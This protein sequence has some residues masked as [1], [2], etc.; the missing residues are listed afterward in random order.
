MVTT[1]EDSRIEKDSLTSEL[2]PSNVLLPKSSSPDQIQKKSQSTARPNRRK[3]KPANYLMEITEE[4]KPSPKT[5][6]SNPSSKKQKNL[7][8]KKDDQK[9]NSKSKERSRSPENSTGDTIEEQ[10]CI[11]K[12]PDLFLRHSKEFEKA[13]GRLEKVDRY[14]FFFGEIPPEFDDDDKFTKAPYNFLVIRKRMENSMY[15]FD[16]K[17]EERI[18]H[19]MYTQTNGNR[20]DAGNIL[21]NDKRI[22]W[23]QF[24]TDILRMC[25]AAIKRDPYA[26]ESS[27]TGTLGYTAVKI[28]ECMQNI[29]Q[30]I[31][32]KQI[33]EMGSHDIKMRTQILVENNKEAA[34]QS[35]WRRKAFPERIYEKL[36]TSNVICSGL[37]S[38]DQSSAEYELITSLPNRFVGIPYSYDDVGQ[39]EDWMKSIS[40]TSKNQEEELAAS[41][42]ARDDGVVKA[43]V[44]TTMDM[45]L[46]SVQDRVMTEKGVLNHAELKSANWAMEEENIQNQP[47][48]IHY[49]AELLEQP[50]WGIDC[51]TRQNIMHC[52]QTNEE[53]NEH[54]ENFIEKWLLPALNACPTE[55]AHN[56]TYAAR[57]LE[58]EPIASFAETC[59]IS[60]LGQMFGEK[61]SRGPSWLKGAARQLRLAVHAL[62]EDAFRVHPKGHGA[63]VLA[64]EGIKANTMVTQYRGEVYP[65]WRWGEKMDAIEE[66]Q[67]K[68]GLRPVLPDFYN[69]VLERPRVDPRGYGLLFVDASRK[70]GLGSLL[71]HSCSPTCHVHVASVSGQLSLVMTTVRDVEQGEELTFDYNA[72]T[73]SLNEYMSAVCL[74]GCVKCRR[75]FLHYATADCYQQ[76]LARNAPVAVRLCS[77]IKASNKQVMS[78]QDEKV[79]HR[80]G[81][82]EAV[83]GAIS[84]IHRNTMENSNEAYESDSIDFVPIWLRTYIAD[85]L[86]YIEYERR[87]L[88]VA[89]LCNHLKKK[90][91]E[92]VNP[93]SGRTKTL[94]SGDKK[95]QLHAKQK[96]NTTKKFKA[97]TPSTQY[98]RSARNQKVGKLGL[99]KNNTKKNPKD[100]AIKGS[101]PQN[102]FLYFS[103]VKRRQFTQVLENQMKP[104]KKGR[105]LMKD[106]QRMAGDVWKKLSDAEKLEWKEKSIESWEDNGGR[107]KERMEMERRKIMKESK[108][109]KETKHDP[110]DTEVLDHESKEQS[111]TKPKKSINPN[112]EEMTKE[113]KETKSESISFEDADAE[114]RMLLEQRIQ[115]LTQTLSRVGRILS[116]HRDNNLESSCFDSL[117]HNNLKVHA[118]VSLM[119]QHD[120]VNFVW[121]DRN[122]IVQSLL[123]FIKTSLFITKFLKT[124]INTIVSS[125][126]NLNAYC[127]S[128]ESKSKNLTDIE[129][130]KMVSQALLDLRRAILSSINM[131]DMDAKEHDEKLKIQKKKEATKKRRIAAQK[132]AETRKLKKLAMLELKT[133]KCSPKK[134]IQSKTQN[135]HFPDSVKLDASSYSNT[136]DLENAEDFPKGD[137]KQELL[138]HESDPY[139]TSSSNTRMPNSRD[140]LSQVNGNFGSSSSSS[141]SSLFSKDSSSN[142][143][144]LFSSSTSQSEGILSYKEDSGTQSNTNSS[145]TSEEIYK[146]SFLGRKMDNEP[147]IPSWVQSNTHSDINSF[148]PTATELDSSPDENKL[149]VVSSMS[150]PSCGASS[151]TLIDDNGKM[152]INCN[153]PFQKAQIKTNQKDSKEKSD[154]NDVFHRKAKFWTDYKNNKYRLEAASDV[155]LFYAHTSN[156]FRIEKY[157]EILSS[158]IEVYARELGNEVPIDIKESTAKNKREAPTT[159]STNSNAIN[160]E[161]K[162]DET[163]LASENVS[164][165]KK[166]INETVKKTFKKG[167]K[168]MFCDPADAIC[169]VARKYSDSYIFYQLLQWFNAGIGSR[170][171]VPDMLGCIILPEISSCFF[172]ENKKITVSENGANTEKITLKPENYTTDFRPMLV[173]WLMD[174]LARGNPWPEALKH[175][176]SKQSNEIGSSNIILGSP[177]M[178]LLVTGD[179]SNISQILYVLGKDIGQIN[180]S[181]I[182][183][184]TNVEVNV[185]GDS[186]NLESTVDEGM[187]VQA[188]M[189]WVQCENPSCMKW[190]KLPFHV[191]VDALPDK[192]Y[193][194]DN[195]WNPESNSCSAPEDEW[196]DDKDAIIDE[197]KNTAV[198]KAKVTKVPLVY[199]VNGECPWRNFLYDALHVNSFYLFN[200]Q[201]ARLDVM[202]PK[203]KKF[204]VGVITAT[205]ITSQKKRIKVHFLNISKKK[206]KNEWILVPSYRIAPLGTYTST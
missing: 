61:L 34:M 79:L 161:N 3:R 150:I 155:L 198:I 73:E 62:G 141:S 188:K 122:G 119:P 77:L 187:P 181:N 20:N 68:F 163:K 52:L 64:T 66:I 95:A 142:G 85:V 19:E 28:K 195:V 160:S 27:A 57:M 69:M 113:L 112:D 148:Y 109:S 93:F 127:E 33:D 65:P 120:I 172:N 176:F 138:L 179:D 140:F 43:Q 84:N 201:K 158:P 60:D 146:T 58:G 80:H 16:R 136:S 37:S 67:E 177:V 17:E 156:F 10:V 206:V 4:S 194:K 81:F 22:H 9:T 55:Q 110:N 2:E 123:Q 129:A 24:Q 97:D 174:R 86:R 45:L 89:L 191:D 180:K 54:I 94:K 48:N 165:L 171:D 98:M 31:G 131:A 51:Y 71:S 90:S 199:E 117:S 99:N 12:P 169:S 144:Y 134:E 76:V 5:N 38:F 202:L 13:L 36:P 203:S 44:K 147:A 121:N 103:N 1:N 157:S 154:S 170:S 197:E 41:A 35:T 25:D 145:Q 53:Y 183:Q 47:N 107:E 106:I 82:R 96:V 101:K 190:R 152:E 15:V 100:K 83:F 193:C 133:L 162:E 128:K 29:F 118:P 111:L 46:I 196:D 21:A 74:C 126:D 166:T 143:N 178:D 102:S 153:E 11:K 105:E 49:S 40:H 175:F 189:N 159:I 137:S 108:S 23:V 200:F 205:D 91:P 149:N 115:A 72:V 139:H 182:D 186:N 56:I 75:S 14:G 88:P 132:G 92:E 116:R 26:S 87:A 30:K 164:T 32:Q 167:R 59:H 78:K 18:R 125:Y 8:K 42:L 70:S 135:E 114:G 39:S 151:S 130:K 63:V 204:T 104:P 7:S 192:F 50:V 185:S 168:K 173:T 124:S 6:E 184:F